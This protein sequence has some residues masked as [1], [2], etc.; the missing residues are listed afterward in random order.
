MALM[1]P[2]WLG[3]DW[4]SGL[5]RFFEGQSA[6]WTYNLVWTVSAF[7]I[8]GLDPFYVAS[9]FSLYLDR[10][11]ALEGWDLEIA[12]RRMAR[13]LHRMEA[14]RS[15]GRGRAASWLGLALVGLLL[16]LAGTESSP[17]LA[18]AQE[19]EPAAE[20]LR[21]AET[22]L[23]ETS[24]GIWEGEEEEDPRTI[25]RE[26]TSRPEFGGTVTAKRWQLREELTSWLE[27]KEKDEPEPVSKPSPILLG[28]V[29][30]LVQVS[31]IALWLVVGLVLLGLVIVAIRKWPE[32]S[33]RSAAPLTEVPE[34]LFGLDLRAESLPPDVAGEA[35]RL[36]RE[37]DV[38]GALSLL[39]RGALK[40]LTDEGVKL[41]ESYTEDDCLR[42]ARSSLEPMRT[43]FFAELTR[44]WQLV[45]YG[46]KL[47]GGDGARW[48]DG[49]RRHFGGESVGMGAS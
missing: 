36:W 6:S 28:I 42:A 39:Y 45:A 19:A 26:I 21:A 15:E 49:W 3:I 32:L 31:E 10:R 17:A 27:E 14:A 5:T 29:W 8:I 2:T 23:P 11:T 20:D 30:L 16:G 24:P 13:R 37:G 46:H 4:D 38:A 22:E 43:G 25:A 9:G 48:W 47:P 35:E 44:A 12:F 33:G 7:L 40:C 18:Q 1:T 34:T 41:A